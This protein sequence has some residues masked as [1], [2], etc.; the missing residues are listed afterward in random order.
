[1]PADREG[2][3]AELAALPFDSVIVVYD[4]EGPAGLQGTLE[5]L[6]RP[7][8]YR[9]ENW[10]LELPLSLADPEPVVETIE[11]SMVQTP[12][13]IWTE[14][15]DG[16]P[17]RRPSPLGPL[18]RAF[19]RLPQSERERVIHNLRDWRAELAAGRAEHPGEVHEVLGKPCLQST[20]AG[21]ALCVWEEA[22]LPLTYTGGPFS[23]VAKHI[24]HDVELGREAFTV[25]EGGQVPTDAPAAFDPDAALSAVA[26]GDLAVLLP[27]LQPA[28]RIPAAETLAAR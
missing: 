12:E 16:S 6:A 11:G 2:F 19:T 22:G 15:I 25:P 17:V 26:Q 10:R 24:E 7:G 9:R 5:V 8:G 21:H 18:A 3:L 14:G 27:L 13:V 28:L 4:V 1:V 20:V 23:V